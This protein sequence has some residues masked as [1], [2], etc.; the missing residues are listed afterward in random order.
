MSTTDFTP[1]YLARAAEHL[2]WDASPAGQVTFA[3][4]MEVEGA[5]TKKA[6]P[7]RMF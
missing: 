5:C 2:G 3:S 1:D 4:S 7:A 6:A